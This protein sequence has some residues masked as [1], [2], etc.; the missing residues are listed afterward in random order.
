MTAEKTDVAEKLAHVTT[1]VEAATKDSHQVKKENKALKLESNTLKKDIM[2]SNDKAYRAEASLYKQR[3][4][5]SDMKTALQTAEQT[6]VILTKRSDDTA[7]KSASKSGHITKLTS[8]NKA[9]AEALATAKTELA[10]KGI[11]LAAQ[12]KETAVLVDRLVR[13][14]KKRVIFKTKFNE[15]R[16]ENRDLVMRLAASTAGLGAASQELA[17]QRAVMATQRS[18][19][20]RGRLLRVKQGN[21]NFMLIRHLKKTLL[22]L[23]VR[24]ETSNRQRRVVQALSRLSIASAGGIRGVE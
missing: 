15:T 18:K 20:K 22:E 9:L 19:I 17:A 10:A 11:E 1:R 3:A 6:I 7:A 24:G 16:A 12:E 8:H 4:K 13:T 14:I 2:E 23:K 5:H 21:V